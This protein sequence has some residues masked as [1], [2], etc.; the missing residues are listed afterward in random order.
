MTTE[1][2]PDQEPDSAATSGRVQRLVRLDITDEDAIKESMPY[3][4][5][6][7]AFWFGK[8]MTQSDMPR[9][10]KKFGMF[11]NDGKGWIVMDYRKDLVRP[12]AMDDMYYCYYVK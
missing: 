7:R 2:K 8:R 3:R 5:G 12:V 1:S 4:E 6:F 10:A 11:M 9:G